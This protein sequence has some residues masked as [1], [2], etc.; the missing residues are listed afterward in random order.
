MIKKFLLR[1]PNNKQTNNLYRSLSNKQITVCL[2]LRNIR[3]N[4]KLLTMSGNR[5]Q[6]ES[7]NSKLDI[8]WKPRH[9]SA[10]C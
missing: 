4:V 5:L 7:A 10:F 9:D 6:I 8:E 3:A 2:I 1:H